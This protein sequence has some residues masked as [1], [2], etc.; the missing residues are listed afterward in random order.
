MSPH[1]PDADPSRLPGMI[2]CRRGL[3]PVVEITPDMVEAGSASELCHNYYTSPSGVLTARLC[4]VLRRRLRLQLLLQPVRRTVVL[5]PGRRLGTARSLR[6]S[7]HGHRLGRMD[8]PRLLHQHG[9]HDRVGSHHQ[10]AERQLG[11]QP[12]GQHD[13]ASGQV[14]N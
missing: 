10:V 6:A 4:A 13:L 11:H 1:Q 7:V 3:E 14:L 9:C 12:P 5:Q 8:R 2:V